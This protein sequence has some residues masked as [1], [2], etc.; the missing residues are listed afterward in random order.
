MD[1]DTFRRILIVDD[2]KDV[3][4]SSALVLE[5]PHREIRIAY[6]ATSALEIA[7]SFAPHV[8]LL[9]I[10]LPDMDGYTLAARLRKNPSMKSALLIAVS[11]YGRDEDHARSASAGIDF[12]LVK[13]LSSSVI[14]DLL[15][16]HH[17][18]RLE[19]SDSG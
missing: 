6:D 7:K 16:R 11:G 8:V 17:E 10:G 12:H 19:D 9:D 3:A 4:D 14:D 1:T 15:I 13:P 18:D 5:R 2:H